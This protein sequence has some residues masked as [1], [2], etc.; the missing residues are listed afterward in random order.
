MEEDQT[1]APQPGRGSGLTERLSHTVRRLKDFDLIDKGLLYDRYDTGFEVRML[2]W[3]TQLTQAEF[4]RKFGFNKI[5]VYEVEN[6]RTSPRIADL[7]KIAQ[8]FGLRLRIS[9]ELP[10]EHDQW[11]VQEDFQELIRSTQ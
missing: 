6:N 4:G 8:A 9:F 11:S 2:R 5:W 1:M 7:Q 3:S 10:T